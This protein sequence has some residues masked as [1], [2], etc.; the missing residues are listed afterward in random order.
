MPLIIP[1]KMSADK[2]FREGDI[3]KNIEVLCRY[4]VRKKAVLVIGPDSFL[5]E[6]I[7]D[8]QVKGYI[9]KSKCNLEQYLYYY[10]QF[11]GMKES[12]GCDNFDVL[13]H[14]KYANREDLKKNFAQ[15]FK[16]AFNVG[17]DKESFKCINPLL[18]Q[19]IETGCFDLILTTT[20]DGLLEK[21]LKSLNDDLRV[22]SIYPD[23]TNKIYD[24]ISI[25]DASAPYMKK[26]LYYLNGKAY[27]NND[28]KMPGYAICDDDMYDVVER[29]MRNF[30]DNN[31]YKYI[32]ERV[33]LAIGCDFDDWLYRMFWHTLGRHMLNSDG[34]KVAYSNAPYKTGSKLEQYFNRT[35][36]VTENNVDNFLKELLDK[37]SAGKTKLDKA[38]EDVLN[39]LK[40]DEGVFISYYS[41]DYEM[42]KCLADAI[43]NMGIRVW[44]DK[45]NLG[46]GTSYTK[47]ILA[48]INKCKVFMPILS[49]NIMAHKKEEFHYYR[50]VEW[51]LSLKNYAMRGNDSVSINKSDY[52]KSI[53]MPSS[54]KEEKDEKGNVV[55]VEF[56]KEQTYNVGD[57]LIM[58]I[59]IE[60]GV[61]HSEWFKA[62]Y[63]VFTRKHIELYKHFGNSILSELNKIFKK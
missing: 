8:E 47:E 62:D 45:K 61:V 33:V 35:G 16:D 41:G 29:W 40:E 34:A 23:T 63:D 31:I 50:E 46:A 6:D 19:L 42:V 24:D 7:D 52:V 27:I 21:Y 43:H 60:E 15:C 10:I 48:A 11:C 58:P 38:Q 53:N 57:M 56:C 12:C 5:S 1:Q 25:G 36:T 26:T 54:I 3:C 18:R 39:E 44:F 22:L 20:V 14:G 13:M 55:S 49:K 30:K 4:I 17:D 51:A 59:Y 28:A 37:D 2:N 32:S 9:S